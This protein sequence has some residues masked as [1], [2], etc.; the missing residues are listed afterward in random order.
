MF[1]C[2]VFIVDGFLVSV[3][4]TNF[5]NR[6]FRLNDEANLN[7]Y[8]KAF[9]A[10]ETV[11]FEADPQKSRQL[12][13]DAWLDRPLREKV[14]GG[15]PGWHRRSF[16]SYRP[17]TSSFDGR[18]SQA[19]DVRGRPSGLPLAFVAQFRSNVRHETRLRY[20]TTLFASVSPSK[21]AP[22]GVKWS[23]TSGW[24]CDTP[25]RASSLLPPACSAMWCNPSAVKTL[26]IRRGGI[27]Q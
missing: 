10:A 23:T 18:S 2:K 21:I 19:F 15:W 25:D 7:I 4:S 5:D 27:D 11:Q 1:H 12:T 16:N 22:S 14:M 20:L 17:T 24:S 9:A 6:S 8:N 26:S 3:G 13:L